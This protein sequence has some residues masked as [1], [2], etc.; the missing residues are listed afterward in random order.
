VK[1]SDYW[2]GIVLAVAATTVLATAGCSKLMPAG[3]APPPQ[4]AAPPPPEVI[5]DLPVKAQVTDFEDFT[6]RTL[7]Y[8]AAEIRPQITGYLNKVYFEE[9]ADV[10]KDD[11]LYE[12]DPRIYASQLERAKGALIQAEA[13]LKRLNSDLARAKVL[14]P[15]KTI[16][17]E[18]FDRATGDQAEADAA[19]NV[20][21]AD[22]RLAEDNLGYT[23]ITA[24]FDGRMSRTML[25]PG[26]LVTANQTV[27]T[28]IVRIDPIYSL[29]GVDERLLK[30]IHDY[31][32]SGLIKKTTDG[33]IPILMGLSDEEGFPRTGYVDFID[34]RLDSNTGTLQV[35]GV[36]ENPNH[37]ILPGLFCRVRLPL[38][39]AYSALT[40]PEQA[41][42]TDQGQKFIYVV[43]DQNKI[44]YRRVEL[45]K[46]QGGQRVVLKGIKDGERVVVS[47]LQRVHPGIEVAPKMAATAESTGQKNASLVIGPVIAGK[48]QASN[49]AITNSLPKMDNGGSSPLRSASGP[50]ALSAA[51]KR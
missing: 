1:R 43:N 7:A 18:E 46:L 9:G 14:F 47:G 41:L 37:V 42:G 26:N 33:K 21:K 23:K 30:K 8:K 16:T 50:T 19:A 2:L 29:F 27:L 25:D 31:V 11:L 3:A 51:E 28:T 45:G 15:N 4:A 22:V 44:E 39:D 6:G 38:G 35:R 17:P 32:Q 10:K 40:I 24:P 20:A 49:N 5:V 12:I 48:T 34:N 36:F 13:H